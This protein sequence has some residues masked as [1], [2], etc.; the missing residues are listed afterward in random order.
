[1]LARSNPSTNQGLSK[2]WGILSQLIYPPLFGFG[3][4]WLIEKK[5]PAQ[6]AWMLGLMLLFFIGGLYSIVKCYLIELA[7]ET[8]KTAQISV[9][10][11]PQES[12]SQPEIP[13]SE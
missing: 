7:E 8:A 12:L 11:T 9:E 13:P 10:P 6:G 5:L 3:L 2:G 1:M 4:G